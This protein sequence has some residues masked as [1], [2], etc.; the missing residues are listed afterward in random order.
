MEGGAKERSNGEIA[1][2]DAR[3]EGSTDQCSSSCNRGYR[4]FDR[5]RSIH[6]I[7][8]NGKVADIILWKKPWISISSIVI[9]TAAWFLFEKTG[10]SFLTICSDVLLI[11]IVVQFIRANAAA[12]LKKQSKPVPELVVSEEMVNSTAATFRARVNSTLMIAHEITL[13]KDFKLFFQ[14]MGFL[15]VLSVIGNFC[16]FFTCAYIGSIVAITLPALYNK[17]EERV[18]RY[19]GIVHQNIS[20]H[21]KVVDQNVIN[22]LPRSLKK[23][24]AS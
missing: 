3:K 16:S 8:G 20:K 19:A 13:G 5:K 17:Y 9:V 1:M 12:L 18:D 22:R 11:L 14:V 15:W 21:Y 4:L 23:E 24:K 10:L 6:Q 2:A 7:V